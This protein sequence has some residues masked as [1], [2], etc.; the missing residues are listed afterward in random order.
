MPSA[1][2][3][4]EPLHDRSKRL[5]R[6]NVAGAA[7]R[8]RGGQAE[9]I[10]KYAVSL[11]IARSLAGAFLLV[12]VAALLPACSPC[13]R[14]DE[15]TARH[16]CGQTK[17]SG[18][19]ATLPPVVPPAPGDPLRT[20]ADEGASGERL[21][22]AV[23]MS[24]ADRQM[25]DATWALVRWTECLVLVGF[26]VGI[27]QVVLLKGTLTET[28]KAATAAQ[29]SA[30]HVR[31][32]ERPWLIMKSA[33]WPENWPKDFEDGDDSPTIV[34]KAQL[35]NHGKTPGWV[36]SMAAHLEVQPWPLPSQ[37]FPCAPESANELPITTIRSH[38]PVL[39]LSMS[40]EAWVRTTSLDSDDT[41][42][43]VF[44]GVVNYHDAFDP[45]VI[46]SHRFCETWRWRRL[47]DE[48]GNIVGAQH[49]YLPIGPTPAWTQNS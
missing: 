24:D 39:T 14:D 22:S 44:Y 38:D 9:T 10:G 33:A 49:Q 11:I 18:Q 4:R 35:S 37:P 26:I 23:G 5:G 41:H 30:D 32:T 27:L 36:T 1:S 42:C 19:S 7:R 31:R 2:V 16:D 12:A 25:V 17:K 47:L 48:Q 29:A 6:L 21:K 45:T 40:E 28:R 43:L 8:D 3:L 13:T 46:H 15:E 20:Q 34:L